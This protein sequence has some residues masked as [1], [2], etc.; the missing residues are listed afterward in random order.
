VLFATVDVDEMQ[1]AAK[2]WGIKAMPTF[3]IVKE[4]KEV[5]RIQGT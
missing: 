3:V 1:E 2:E 5:K 4:G